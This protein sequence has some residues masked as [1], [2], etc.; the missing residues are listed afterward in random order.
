MSTSQTAIEQECV[1]LCTGMDAHEQEN[2]K[3]AADSEA[4]VEAA[5]KKFCD[6]RISHRRKLHD[7]HVELEGAMNEIGVRCMLYPEKGSTIG[8]ITAW[9]TQEIQALLDAIAKANKNF[10]VYCLIGILK[11]L[12]EHTQCSHVARV[13]GIM[14]AYDAFIFDNVPA[15]ILKISARIVK[16][17][18]TSYGLP[19]VTE[20]SHFRAEVRFFDSVLAFL[21]WCCLL[22]VV[23]WCRKKMMAEMKL[24]LLWLMVVEVDRLRKK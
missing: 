7:L 3:I 12:Q 24:R 13:E 21:I 22:T 1:K 14:S 17:W 18:W 4:R 15:D 11:M 5:E 2:A 16:K 9:F 19:Y 8:V 20:V 6:Y 23:I 10:L